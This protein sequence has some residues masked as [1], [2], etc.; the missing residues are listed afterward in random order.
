MKAI[1]ILTLVLALSLLL[2]GLAGSAVPDAIDWWV[3]AGGSGPLTDGG[4]VTLNATLGQPIIG[5]STG[6]HAQLSA[7]FWQQATEPPAPDHFIYLP[8]VLRNAP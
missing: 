3:I 8:V 5:A 7:G 4:H 6:D 2:V 1:R